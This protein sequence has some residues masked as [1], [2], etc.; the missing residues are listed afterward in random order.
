MPAAPRHAADAAASY[1]LDSIETLVYA[2]TH[3]VLTGLPNRGVLLDRLARELAREDGVDRQVAVLFVDLDNFKL[4]NDSLG[5]ESGDEVLREMSRRIRTCACDGDTVSRFGGDELVVLH[6]CAGDGSENLLG[7]RILA[8]MIRPIHVAGREVVVS[9]SVG[10][11]ICSCGAE[12]AEHLL[13]EADTALY[14]AKS[15]GRARIARFSE[16]LREPQLYVDYQPQVDLG[17]GRLVGVEALARWRHPERGLVSP[18]EFIPAA[19]D[20]GLIGELERQVLRT[21]CSQLARWHQA[22][23][24][25]RFTLT[26]N[27]SPRQIEAPGFVDELRAILDETG[28]HPESLCLEL[29]ESALVNP[30]VDMVVALKRIRAMGVYLAIDDFGTQH[31]SLARLRGLPIE[32]LK[33]D[34]SF[35][36]GLSTEPEDTAIVSSILSL[37]FAMG[38]HVIADGVE[39]PEQAAAL[40][41]MGCAVAQGYLFGAPVA[42]EA[43]VPL[44]SRPLWQPQALRRVPAAGVLGGELRRR[45]HRSFIDEFLDHIGAPMGA[46][47]RAV[48]RTS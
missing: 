40:H 10:V 9:V 26:V 35:I 7:E 19:E 32:V 41:G 5:H 27:V 15:R 13:R 1:N 6:P 12:P 18:T 11:A 25:S 8:E 22:S 37:A 24:A 42:P 36:D 43:I 38:K 33:I 47:T 2:A 48:K 45:G 46:K 4:I 28:V 44:L 16:E 31:S 29:A 34:R 21:A 17:T 39:R 23:P 14:A 20:C 30:D 3:D